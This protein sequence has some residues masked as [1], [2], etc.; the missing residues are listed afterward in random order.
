MRLVLGLD[1]L[2]WLTS[3]TIGAAAIDDFIGPRSPIQVSDA[4]WRQYDAHIA[5]L[6]AQG[7][8]I[9]VLPEKIAVLAPAQARERQQHLRTLARQL[10]IWLVAGAGEDNGQQRLNLAWLAGP[11]GMVHT[12]QKQHLAPPERDFS[13]GR[14]SLLHP[15]DGLSYG[16]AICKDMHFASLGLAYARQGTSVMLVPAWDFDE[17]GALAAAITLTRGVEGGYAIVRAA[18]NGL[19]T[20]TDAYGRVRARQRSSAMPGSVLLATVPTGRPA[21]TL[22]ART[23]ALFGWLCALLSIV[24]LAAS[25]DRARSCLHRAVNG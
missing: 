18:R 11:D 10:G 9:V 2:W 14:A 4:V 13:A 8:R 3:V 12:Y 5:T 7:A 23:G 17:D 20:V 15:I 19:L 24:M 16:L 25:T 6:A 21:P 22:Y 1:P